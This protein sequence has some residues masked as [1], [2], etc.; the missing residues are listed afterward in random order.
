MFPT[1]TINSAF[2]ADKPRS[3]WKTMG[4]VFGCVWLFEDSLPA[5]SGGLVLKL[6]SFFCS[7]SGD[8]HKRA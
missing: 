3:I 2:T 5:T 7:I 1:Q 4:Q 8:V 6:T